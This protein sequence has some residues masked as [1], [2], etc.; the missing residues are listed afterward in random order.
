MEQY[1]IVLV[2]HSPT[3]FHSHFI[4][5]RSCILI[6][7]IITHSTIMSNLIQCEICQKWCFNKRSL[8]THLGFCRQR[9]TAFQDDAN[10]LLHE[11]NP[12]QSSYNRGDNLNPFAVYDDLDFSNIVMMRMSVSAPSS[13]HGVTANEVLW[14]TQR[15]TGYGVMCLYWIL[16]RR[17]PTSGGCREKIDEEKSHDHHWCQRNLQ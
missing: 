4:L 17:E 5:P 7:H 1:L 10:H 11:H 2:F 14:L 8:L 6:C 16:R 13:W 3:F 15:R 9:H 12:L